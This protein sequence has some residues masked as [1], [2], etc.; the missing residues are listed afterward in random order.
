MY[1]AI[2]A[3]GIVLGVRRRSTGAMLFQ[4]KERTTTR[5][6]AT[7]ATATATTCVTTE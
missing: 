3:V 1:A 7:T 2:R 5:T 4:E 6:T